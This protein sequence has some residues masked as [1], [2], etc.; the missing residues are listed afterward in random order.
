MVKKREEQLLAELREENNKKAPD[1]YIDAAK[2]MTEI[3]E[4]R[5]KKLKEELDKRAKLWNMWLC[6]T[7][8]IRSFRI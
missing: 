4:K 7:N 8:K 1:S 6:Y 3:D 2:I 5:T